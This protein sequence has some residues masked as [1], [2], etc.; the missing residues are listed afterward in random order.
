MIGVDRFKEI[1]KDDLLPSIYDF[2]GEKP[3]KDKDL[4]LKYLKSGKKS[5][6]AP[7]KVKDVIT[8]E[9]INIE[10]CC[11]TDGLYA[12][13]SDLIYYVDKYNLKL[14]DDFVDYIKQKDI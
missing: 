4:V 1:Y 9:Y 2:I 14:Q 3:Y 6:V 10:L 11:Y 12:W 5:A 7:A 8:N 13:R